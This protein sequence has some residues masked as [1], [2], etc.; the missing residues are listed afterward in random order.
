M[1]WDFIF[2]FFC[3][4]V[5]TVHRGLSELSKGGSALDLSKVPE[6]ENI[7]SYVIC[8]FTELLFFR[9]EDPSGLL[10]FRVWVGISFVFVHFVLQSSF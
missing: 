5:F 8:A 1:V 3:R 2:L 4:T 10:A 7:N 9:V 6:K